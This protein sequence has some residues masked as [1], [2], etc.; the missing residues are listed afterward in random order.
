MCTGKNRR[1]ALSWLVVAGLFM[2]CGVLGALQYLW[3][4][5][6]SVAARDRL[7]GSLQASLNRLSLDFTTEIDTACR[8][9][10]P[11]DSGP[12]SPAAET[13]VAARYTQW[14]KTGRHGQ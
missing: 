1:R 12:D 9:L 8:A 10:L 2:L 4:G 6:I 14:K 7:R 5:Q 3:T 11:A 13:E